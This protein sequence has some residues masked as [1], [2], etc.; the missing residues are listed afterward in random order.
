M[1][2]DAFEG[3]SNALEM[4][5][6]IQAKIKKGE[7]IPNFLTEGLKEYLKDQD[8]IQELLEKALAEVKN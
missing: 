7:K 3:K 2:W 8:T 4:I 1:V 6:E 5:H